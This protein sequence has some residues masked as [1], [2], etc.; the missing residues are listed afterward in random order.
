M[1]LFLLFCFQ[2]TFFQRLTHYSKTDEP[3]ATMKASQYKPVSVI[4][5]NSYK[6]A[7]V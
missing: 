2:I 3:L 5:F 6:N 4:I 1:Q 7:L